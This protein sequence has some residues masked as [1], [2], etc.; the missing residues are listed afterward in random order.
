[1]ELNLTR[2][3]EDPGVDADVRKVGPRPRADGVQDHLKTGD[4]GEMA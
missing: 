1:M 2:G 3:G 4:C